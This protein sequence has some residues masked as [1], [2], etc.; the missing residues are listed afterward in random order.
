MAII[1]VRQKVRKLNCSFLIFIN[2]IIL[3]IKYFFISVSLPAPIFNN[4]VGSKHFNIS[5]C[6]YIAF[7]LNSGYHYRV[8]VGKG[9][10]GVPV[11]VSQGGP[12]RTLTSLAAVSQGC[13]SL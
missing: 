10:Q 7:F 4:A 5:L 13:F 1:Y 8:L 6:I 12:G 9:S 3:S 2:F 11:R